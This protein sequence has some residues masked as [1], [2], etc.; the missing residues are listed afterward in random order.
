MINPFSRSYTRDELRLFEFLQKNK[1]FAH[2]T[3]KEMSEFLPH[4]YLRNYQ[5]NEV[6]FFRND[7]SQALYL[8]K[9]GTI[10]LKVDVNDNFETFAHIKT[11]ASLGNNALI[12]KTKR[13]YSAIVESE[14]AQL[15]VVPQVNILNIFDSHVKIKA[16]VFASL[17][18]IYNNN[19]TNLMKAY[20]ATSGFFDLEQVYKNLE[21]GG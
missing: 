20:Q 14:T 3:R 2:L 9:S 13:I 11:N 19:T 4:L 6:I 10:A 15:Y 12:E 8:I 7:P 17:A 5:H 1:L 18:A 21:Y 16:K